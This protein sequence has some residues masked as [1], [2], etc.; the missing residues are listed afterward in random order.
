[1]KGSRWPVSLPQTWSTY[2]DHYERTPG[3]GSEDCLPTG[4][5]P[6]TGSCL[7]LSL[8]S[9]PREQAQTN[10][11]T[12]ATGS[13]R[14]GRTDVAIPNPSLSIERQGRRS[15]GEL[16]LTTRARAEQTV[17]GLSVA[18]A[19]CQRRWPVS[20]T[21]RTSCVMMGRPGQRCPF[22]RLTSSWLKPAM[23]SACR[24]LHCTR[25]SP[26]H[27]QSHTESSPFITNGQGRRGAR[28]IQ[29]QLLLSRPPRDRVASSVVSRCVSAL[30]I[31]HIW[32]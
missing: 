29:L 19:L 3:P 8:A 28:C 23:L 30:L 31:I 20:A 27:R 14:P 2:R 11:N 7:S 18:R 10:T 9:F 1:M 12:G 24:A 21:V 4:R 32:A 17:R 5:P 25:P 22:P 15:L 13:Q 16:K 6:R 26:L